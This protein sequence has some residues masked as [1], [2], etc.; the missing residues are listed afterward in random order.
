[1][2]AALLAAKRNQSSCSPQ[3]KPMSRTVTRL[4]DA[5]TPPRAKSARVGDPV[6]MLRLYRTSSLFQITRSRAI[7]CSALHA[8]DLAKSMND[9]DKVLLSLHDCINRLV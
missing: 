4:R 3:Q 2:K 8:H 7:Q 5:T 9:L 1:M 6:A